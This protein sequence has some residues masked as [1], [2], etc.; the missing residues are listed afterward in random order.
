MKPVFIGSI[1][2]TIISAGMFPG[3]VVFLIASILTF[4]NFVLWITTAPAEEDV[5]SD[6]WL[7]ELEGED[8]A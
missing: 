6:A 2:L 5:W 3:I 1:I 7:D 8:G 4:V